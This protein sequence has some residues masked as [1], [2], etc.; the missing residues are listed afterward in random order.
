MKKA[1]IAATVLAISV[2]L[3]QAGTRADL[4]GDA[5]VDFQTTMD[6]PLMTVGS[7]GNTGELSGGGAGGYGPDRICG[8]VDYVYNIGKFEVTT[9]QYTEFLNA[10]AA[11]DTYDLYDTR[12]WSGTSFSCKIERSGTS[13]SY[14]Y[15]VA[16]DWTDRPINYVSWGDAARFVNW[17]NNGMP[18]GS[19]DLNTTEDGSYFLNGA[20]SY[21]ALL[22]VTRKGDAR[23]VIPSEDEWYKAAYHKNDGV[24][25][26]YFD[27]PQSSDS[28]PSNVVIDPD[29]GTNANFLSTIGS[30]YYRTEVGEFENS[31]SPYETFDMGGNVWEYNEAVISSWHGVRGAPFYGANGH[32]H[33]SHR[34]DI[35]FVADPTG[36]GGVGFRVAQILNVDFD[37]D[38]DVDSDD[39][40][41]LCDNM[42]GD[43]ATYDTNGDR[44]VDE[45]DLIYMV[46]NLV[47]WSRPGG[48]SGVGTERGDFN[49]DGFVN[50]TD[51]AIMKQYFGNTGIGWAGG[52]ANCDDIINATDLAILKE[53]FGFE[54]TTVAVPEPVSLSLL[55][56]GAVLLLRR[57]RWHWA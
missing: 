47:E 52:N 14:T 51:L 18:T 25:G 32:Q 45:D 19:Q 8:A 22:T 43:P 9:G 46:E 29:P 15:S 2:G 17:L 49:L 23:Y 50:A 12:M 31:D 13:G 28:G 30:P 40:D 26:N 24:T 33:A 38:G 35:G 48:F 34:Y 39:I 42:G 7:P 20:T 16:S 53:S 21:S 27:F 36:S 41:I 57:R 1:I 4:S 11:T 6:M 54:A 37:D 56:A 55:G 10:V 3:A 5:I 44:D